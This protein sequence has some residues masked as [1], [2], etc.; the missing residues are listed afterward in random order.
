MPSIPRLFTPQDLHTGQTVTG[1]AE[2]LHY[3]KAVLRRSPGETVMLFNGR[4]GEWHAEVA[5]VRREVHFAVRGQLRPQS[6]EPDLWL[7]FAIL[8]REATELI[9]QK[10]TEL[11]V[12]ALWPVTTQ[13][14][15]PS[16]LNLE[17]MR[18]IGAEA[19]E[20]SE[21]L[22]VPVIHPAQKL[23][24]LLATWP[25]GRDLFVAAERRLAPPPARSGRPGALLVGPEGGFASAELEALCMYPFVHPVSLGPRVLRAETAAIAGLALLLLSDVAI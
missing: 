24:D 3:L 21:R 22:S 1:S 10:A 15:Q 25:A 16:R 12:A 17:R 19:A 9:V 18:M 23:S 8:K 20:Q 4:D 13:R 6:A 7:V 14:T 2:Q 5:F 11:G